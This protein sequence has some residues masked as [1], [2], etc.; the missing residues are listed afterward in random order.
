MPTKRRLT[1]TQLDRPSYLVP[2]PSDVNPANPYS[3]S[4][5]PDIRYVQSTSSTSATTGHPGALAGSTLANSVI[6]SDDESPLSLPSVK[7]R[8]N[9]DVPFR[10]GRPVLALAMDQMLE[11]GKGHA[12]FDQAERSWSD[13]P[14]AYY[15]RL[16]DA[17]KQLPRYWRRKA[18]QLS[19]V[20]VYRRSRRRHS[21]VL[22]GGFEDDRYPTGKRTGSDRTSFPLKRFLL[23]CLFLGGFLIWKKQSG[24]RLFVYPE[25]P[26]I[27]GEDFPQHW[28]HPSLFGCFDA[29]RVGRT[30]YNLTRW[31]EGRARHTLNAGSNM[32]F[33]MEC[34]DYA[35]TIRPDPA[36][37][38]MLDEDVATPLIYHT[39]WRV[40]LLPFDRRQV[41]TIDSFLATQRTPRSRLYLWTND[42]RNL[43]TNP[44]VERYVREWPEVFRVK[45]IDVSEMTAGTVLHQTEVLEQMYDGSAWVDGDAVRLLAL[46]NHGG[47][48]FDM[49]EIL[50][51]DLNVLAE[52]E[53]VTQWDC[54]GSWICCALC[55]VNHLLNAFGQ[56]AYFR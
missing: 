31:T 53:F 15:L 30:D 52:H 2:D 7:I 12:T 54:R 28:E 20:P 26:I 5:S 56:F 27:E 41:A 19:P 45:Q 17:I 34:Y 18:R 40:D 37:D 21:M 36:Y 42:V 35:G 29:E 6:D 50:T 11:K 16:S 4:S 1:H 55:S 32:K 46:W 14:Y 10:P 23:I 13:A 3:R 8:V 24:V 51:R 43:T 38:R 39:Y 47:I 25:P 44:L 22:S 33:E 9:G 49:D 48:W